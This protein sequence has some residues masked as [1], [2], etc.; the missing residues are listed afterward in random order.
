MLVVKDKKHFKEVKKFAEK[1]GKESNLQQALDYLDRYSG[2]GRTRCTLYKDFAPFSFEFLMERKK[3]DGE[4]E[5]WF[6]G[7][8]V[9]HGPEDGYGSGAAPA[10]S[11]TLE[12]TH[13]WS[14]HT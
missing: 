11:V 4:F 14:I 13:G 5:P 9:W 8:I 6:N 1:I 3:E 7:G 12:P 2:E 10:L